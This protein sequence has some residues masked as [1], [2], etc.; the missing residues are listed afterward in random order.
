[1]AAELPGSLRDT[2]RAFE[3]DRTI[4]AV[5]AP[6]PARD[7]LIALAAFASELTRFPRQVH[8]PM[9]AEIRFQWWRDALHAGIDGSKSGNPIADAFADT[10]RRHGLLRSAIDDLLDA[11]AHRLYASPPVDDAAL[12]LECELTE[13]T[14]FAFAAKILGADATEKSRV[15]ISNTAQAYG[16]ARLGIDLPY[17]LSRGRTPFPSGLV[18]VAEEVPHNWRPAIAHLCRDAR[19][20]LAN[21]KPHFSQASPALRAA[22]LPVALVE[23]YLQALERP[24]HDAARD[25][26][27]IVPLTRLWRLSLASWR[28]RV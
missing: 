8:D 19:A 17:A 1:M 11:H 2:A 12:S 18:T 6:R 21:V 26:V 15:L 20:H 25:L 7:D 9:A 28:G 13:G 4:A 16:R 24:A 14:L 23:P 5:L 27:E 10:L 22:L 3:P